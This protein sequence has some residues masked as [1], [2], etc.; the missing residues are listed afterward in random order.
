[1]AYQHHQKNQ[2]PPQDQ[3]TGQAYASQQGNVPSPYESEFKRLDAD[4]SGHL[5][6]S[7]LKK[8]F[9]K[10]VPTSIL[11]A[12]MKAADADK[13]GKLSM[14]EYVAIRQQLGGAIPG[15]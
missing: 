13:D 1:M 10:W 3:R 14:Q 12:A 4:S 8:L 5:E 7:E 6:K 11:D 9:G 15:L 2:R